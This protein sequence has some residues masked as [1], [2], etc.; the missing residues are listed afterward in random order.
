[1]RGDNESNLPPSTP[2]WQSQNPKGRNGEQGKKLVINVIF[3]GERPGSGEKAYVGSVNEPSAPKKHKKEPI[4]FT[5]RDLPI[6]GSTHSHALVISLN[7]N[8]TLVRR[9]LVDIGSSVNVMYHDV[10]VKLG[11]SEDQLIPLK[12]PLDGFTGDTVETR[13]QSRYP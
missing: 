7:L 13:G 1:M 6:G 4:V 8:G 3:G 9:V 12:T 2:L 10:Y 11:L 5:D